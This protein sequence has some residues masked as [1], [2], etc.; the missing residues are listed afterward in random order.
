MQSFPLDLIKPY[1]GTV[2]WLCLGPTQ[3]LLDFYDKN[4]TEVEAKTPSLIL[5]VWSCVMVYL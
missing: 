3:I 2:I 5:Q 4:I 1:I